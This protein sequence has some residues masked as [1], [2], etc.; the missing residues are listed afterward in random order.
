MYRVMLMDDEA[1]V[2]R[3]IKAKIDW[4]AA[5]F[6]IAAEA[7]NGLEG[8]ELLQLLESESSPLPDLVVTDIRMPKM[9][10]IEFIRE[11]KRLYP[12]LRLVVL[13]GYSD[14][15]Y[16]KAA[17]Q[18]GVKD[19]LLKPVVRGELL[20][21]LG[22]LA[23]ELRQERLRESESRADEHRQSGQMKL[24]REQ[25]LLQLVKDDWYSFSATRERARQLGLAILEDERLTARF[26][27]VEMRIP[28]GRLGDGEE[29]RDLLQ[30]AFRLLCR[31]TADRQEGVYPFYDAGHSSMMF[32]LIVLPEGPEGEERGERF[33]RELKRNVERYLRLESVAGLGEPIQGLSRLKNGYASCM[34]S[35]SRSTV[36]ISG[37]AGSIAEQEEA[38]SPETE[39]RL[40]QAIENLD[41][42]GLRAQL[43]KLFSP[44][45]DTSRFEF[46]FLALRVLLLLSSVAKKFETGDPALQKL[47]WD[48]QTTI[49]SYPSREEAM[50]R[51]VR[52]AD[53]VVQAVKRTRASGGV[54][55]AEAV[56][57]YVDEN[58]SYEL[59]LSSLAAMF[60]LNE[61]YLSG[62]FK[63]IAGVT[64]SD[65]LTATRM[66]RAEELL[67]QGDL[68][69]TDIA[70]LVGYS[71][72]SY[73]ST[74]FKKHYGTSPKEYRD[75]LFS[76]G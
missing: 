71:S 12:G 17:I 69:L 62:L 19:Y 33:V 68:K 11:C 72:S 44:D 54:Q 24:L 49:A 34:L 20:A 42:D 63:Q 66:K 8:L 13:S 58:Y 59:T 60:H 48:C 3:S 57:K 9:D 10:G 61:T 16:M 14:F 65:Y 73:F 56:K 47:L 30:L 28:S 74:A 64:F 22:K 41:S 26:A 32:F 25:F 6:E 27:A 2:R 43:G 55:L 37:A 76:S 7:S 67:R 46:T 35:W 18:L 38:F 15:E 4:E 29:R 23:E 36:R 50:E 53:K 31:E 52:L 5:G 70:M 39:R 1:G 51:I 40:I 45:A 21:L 75:R